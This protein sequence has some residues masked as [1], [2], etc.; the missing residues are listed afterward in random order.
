MHQLLQRAWIMLEIAV[1]A[2]SDK[3]MVILVDLS[4]QTKDYFLSGH[5]DHGRR[6]HAARETRLLQQTDSLFEVGRGN[7]S[8]RDHRT[9]PQPTGRQ[10]E[11]T[12]LEPKDMF[13]CTITDFVYFAGG[14]M[15][16]RE[17]VREG[18]HDV[19]TAVGWELAQALE[20]RGKFQ[21]S[22][23]VWNAVLSSE[24]KVFGHDHMDWRR[25]TTISA[26][27]T[28]A[29]S[30]KKK[31][32]K[33]T[34]NRYKSKSRSST[35]TITRTWPIP[36]TRSPICSR[37]GKRDEARKLFLKCE[38]I[39]SK[40]YSSDHTETLDAARRAEEEEDKVESEEEDEE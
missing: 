3:S 27:F 7:H 26:M 33:Y 24:I 34:R 2:A 39:Y 23:E 4:G 16:V 31:L 17:A 19:V 8:A 21:D 36:S 14:L 11:G 15:W 25:R 13:N 18:R 5:D 30:S 6:P 29:R 35:A 40:M 22:L 28:I 37:K 20:D 9:L 1:R 38:K 32:S 10:F 12:G